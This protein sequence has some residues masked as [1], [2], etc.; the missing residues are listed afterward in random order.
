MITKIIRTK[1]MFMYYHK[2]VWNE[3]VELL[4]SKEVEPTTHV[5]TIKSK[6][7]YNLFN[8]RIDVLYGCFCC[9]YK[10]NHKTNLFKVK[11]NIHDIRT[12]LNGI[13]EKFRRAS[14]YKTK[15]KYAKLI[16]DFKGG[17]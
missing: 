13:Y 3:I 8:T 15:I 10:V 2:L 11:C 4:E 12:C 7:M 5:I 1:K 6:A 17:K 14:T 16:R 9:E